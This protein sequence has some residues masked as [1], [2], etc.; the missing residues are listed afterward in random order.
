MER[1]IEISFMKGANP[2][3]KRVNSELGFLRSIRTWDGDDG[4]TGRREIRV[5]N[6][7]KQGVMYHVIDYNERGGVVASRYFLGEK[8]RQEMH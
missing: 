7:P 4:E 6:E 5:L 2:S 1:E 3:N 8:L